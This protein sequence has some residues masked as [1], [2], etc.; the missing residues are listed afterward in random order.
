MTKNNLFP[1]WG[2]LFF[3]CAVLGLLP[4]PEDGIRVLFT[5]LSLLFFLPPGILVYQSRKAKDG[6]TL[7]LIRTL[8]AAS[9]C[10]TL[11]LLLLSIRTAMVSDALGR[12]LHIVLA[13]VSAPMMVSGYWALSLFL[14]ACLFF[15]CKM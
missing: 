4:A 8:S 5:G 9:L 1:I 3:I 15:A 12:F 11:G 6:Q 14:W 2:I 10:L 13:I 7:K